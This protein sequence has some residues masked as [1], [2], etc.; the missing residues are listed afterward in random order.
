MGL[1]NKNQKEP[2]QE[3]WEQFRHGGKWKFILAYGV[4]AWGLS[5]ALLISVIDL[6]I[7]LGGGSIDWK[8]IALNFVWFPLGGVLLGSWYWWYNERKYC[9]EQARINGTNE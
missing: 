1:F 8:G 7:A 6:L 5:V 3:N 4:V 2:Y 9:K